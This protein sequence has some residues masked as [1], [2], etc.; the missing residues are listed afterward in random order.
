MDGWMHGGVYY[1]VHFCFSLI[2]PFLQ[3]CLFSFPPRHSLSLSP[4]A[5]CFFCSALWSLLVLLFP[6]VLHARLL[7]IMHKLI[8]ML[9]LMLIP[10]L[11]TTMKMIAM[12][13][14]SALHALV[15]ALVVPMHSWAL[16][17]GESPVNLQ[18]VIFGASPQNTSF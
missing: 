3:F 11:M 15:D 1:V 18:L 9:I 2:F 16:S 17:T 12:F 10:M 6:A 14:S 5:A 13:Y 8:T 4:P 7:G